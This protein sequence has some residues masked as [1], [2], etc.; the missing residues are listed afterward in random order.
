MLGHVG[1][2]EGNGEDDMLGAGPLLS[3]QNAG[4]HAQTLYHICSCGQFSLFILSLVR[5]TSFSCCKTL[6]HICKS[7]AV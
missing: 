4:S 1:T 3:I 2:T 6:F 7:V 5:N